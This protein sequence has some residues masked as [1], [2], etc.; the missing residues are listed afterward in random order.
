RRHRVRIADPL[1]GVGRS[2]PS[3]VLRWVRRDAERASLALVAGVRGVL[4][5]CDASRVDV[6]APP[7]GVRVL[8]DSDVPELARAGGV[9][10]PADVE[11]L[12]W[13]ARDR[14]AWRRV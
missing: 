13:R 4:V 9:L 3:P 1:V 10:K 7:R 2:A 12:Y 5:L 11:A 6:A 8:R 14:R